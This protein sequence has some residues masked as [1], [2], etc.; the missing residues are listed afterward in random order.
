MNRTFINKTIINKTFMLLLLLITLNHAVAFE[1]K[2]TEVTLTDLLSTP[3]TDASCHNYC[4]LGMCVWLKCTLFACSIE[5]S[6]RVGH[7]NPDL[8]V[9]V[10]DGPGNNPFAAARTL[11]GDLE[12]DAAN[13]FVDFFHKAKAGQGHRVEG[14]NR[15]TDQSLRYGEATAVGNPLTAITDFASNAGLACPSETTPMQLYFSSGFDAL[16]WR[17]GLAEMVYLQNFLPGVRVIGKGGMA[18]QWGSVFPRTG[19]VLQK[20]Y[21]KAAAVLSQRVGNIV[22]QKQQ[23]HVY[24]APNGNNYNRSWLPGELVE[25]D[26]DTGVWQMVAPYQDDQCYVF[27]ENDV[28]KKRWSHKRTSEDNSYAFNVWRP[29]ECCKKKG[30]F[31][32]KVDT[33]P[34]CVP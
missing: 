18:Q 13:T 26:A 12:R 7:N 10:Y 32:F 34:V 22:T 27:G 31:L 9:T 19:F 33:P 1:A 25:N 5:T 4:V 21:A 6:L 24:T 20:D 15:Y 16:T 11:Y 3:I 28:F 14:G 17:L 29:Y 2:K 8:L 23:P 30:A